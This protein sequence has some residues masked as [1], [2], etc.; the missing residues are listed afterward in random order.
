MPFTYECYYSHTSA[1]HTRVAFT[2]ECQ[3][4]IYEMLQYSDGKILYIYLVIW[5]T[6]KGSWVDEL[7]SESW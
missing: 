2:H 6:P 5:G 7:G 3:K 1:I 4:L